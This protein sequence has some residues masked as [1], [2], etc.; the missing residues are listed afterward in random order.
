M[1]FKIVKYFDFIL[2]FYK[3]IIL[4][5]NEKKFISFSKNF[6][7]K[8]KNKKKNILIEITDDYYF[9]CYF[10][11]IFNSRL[12]N[13][14]LIGYWPIISLSQYKTNNFFLFFFYLRRNIYYFFLRKKWKKIYSALGIKEIYD[15]N[16]L[17]NFFINNDEN[18]K[19]EKNTKKIFEN[20]TNKEDIL[21]INFSEVDC[22]N[23]I[24]DTYIRFINLPTI[25]IKSDALKN[26]IYKSLVLIKAFK[27]FILYKNFNFFYSGY[28]TYIHHGIPV[29]MF[30]KMKREVFTCGITQ[31][32][33]KLT[34]EDP[35]HIENYKNFRSDFKKIRN[36]KK[37]LFLAKKLV[38]A[39]F[40]GIK[41]SAYWYMRTNPYKSSISTE[42]EKLKNNKIDGI[43]FLPNFFECQREWGDIIFPDFYEWII[44]TLDLITSYNL[45]IAI[46]PHPN[47]YF[48]NTESLRVVEF[49]KKKYPKIIWIHP[50]TSNKKILKKIKFGI[51]PWGSVIWELAFYKKIAISIG[52]HPAKYYN[53][54][55]IPKNKSEYKKML[56][57][58]SSLLK[59]K[60]S[61]E[62]I[63]EYIYMMLIH[64][65]DNYLND[66]RKLNIKK[67][68]FSNSNSL[69]VFMRSFSTLKSYS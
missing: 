55:Y 46:K 30:L 64:N 13:A 38:Q 32:N 57:K 4:D 58:S 20:I 59:K 29:R 56:I 42:I 51:S 40:S 62:D 50:N 7:V 69:D 52:N 22:G 31:Y 54:A 68:D 33:K 27:K 3:K 48:V 25:D 67:I 49:L 2:K 41:E 43:I 12:K 65:N 36:K 34:L 39:H 63:Y 9:L 17:K 53:L 5:Q 60:Y 61:L 6:L 11:L 1:I 47:T 14:N 45:K 10:F 35:N 8:N 23:L 24:Y 18:K 37:C 26:I 28:S 15:Y 16:N 66:A 44:Y 21:K 19:L